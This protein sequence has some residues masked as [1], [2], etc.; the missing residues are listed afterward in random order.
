MTLLPVLVVD[1]RSTERV[2]MGFL[3]LDLDLCLQ[4]LLALHLH[5]ILVVLTGRVVEGLGRSVCGLG[6]SDVDRWMLLGLEFL[7]GSVLSSGNS[8]SS[9]SVAYNCISI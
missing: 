3:L 1:T 6:R 7:S 2:T 5:L 9:S 8:F 4:L